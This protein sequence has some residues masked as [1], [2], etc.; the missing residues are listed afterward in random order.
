MLHGISSHL[1]RLPQANQWS[2]VRISTFSLSNQSYSVSEASSASGF[3][4]T[5]VG[6]SQGKFYWEIEPS[7]TGTFDCAVGIRRSDEAVATAINLGKTC[8]MRAN[9]TLFTGDTGASTGTGATF[10]TGNR[11]MGAMDLVPGGTN[12]LWLGVNGTW[13]NSGNP[14]AG[15]GALFSGFPAGE[16]HLFAWTDNNV[17]GAHDITLANGQSEIL[18][19]NYSVPDGFNRGL[20]Y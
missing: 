3:V 17:A 19:F 8:A 13:A 6:R 16:W 4:M 15:T 11:L 9:A 7:A 5:R 1:K 10:A 18:T 14:A 20:R 2:A 12:K